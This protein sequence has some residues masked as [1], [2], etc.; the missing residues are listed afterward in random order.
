MNESQHGWP[1]YIDSGICVE[2]E[3]R[4]WDI[5]GN[6][7]VFDRTEKRG[8]RFIRACSPGTEAYA[9][10][11][12]ESATGLLRI[13]KLYKSDVPAKRF[14]RIA[15]LIS[16]RLYEW[17]PAFLGVPRQW[18][19][20]T[21][22]GQP[23]GIDR[24][25]SGVLLAAVPGSTWKAW[26]PQLETSEVTWDDNVRLTLA[27]QLIRSLAIL[28]SAGL[29]HGDISEGNVLI[30]V[31][32]TD[33]QL[34]LI[35]FDGFVFRPE[36]N[37]GLIRRWAIKL[38]RRLT[39]IPTLFSGAFPP[40]AV[41]D[42]KLTVAE[43]GTIGTPYYA[44][45]DLIQKCESE[46]HID[47]SPGTDL[48]ARDILLIELLCLGVHD[49]DGDAPLDW[50]DSQREAAVETIQASP[51]PMQHLVNG[52]QLDLSPRQ[53]PTSIE[54]AAQ[55]SI[56][57]PPVHRL[58][59]TDPLVLD[60]TLPPDEPTTTV[61]K[62]IERVLSHAAILLVV[63]LACNWLFTHRFRSNSISTSE[64]K[65]KT[66]SVSSEETD[67]N[68]LAV[69]RPELLSR[70]KS[71]S[72]DSPTVLETDGDS[73][74][75]I[76]SD[77][78]NHT[79]PQPPI[80]KADLGFEEIDDPT[81]VPG[82]RYLRT[83]KKR[84]LF[85]RLSKLEQNWQRQSYER[86]RYSGF[87]FNADGTLLG[88]LRS[89]GE[90]CVVDTTTNEIKEH[91]NFG[92]G[93]TYRYGRMVVAST[94]KVTAL[95]RDL[96]RG[97]VSP[98]ALI[99]LETA[100]VG[101]PDVIVESATLNPDYFAVS[102]DG[103]VVVFAD[104]KRRATIVNIPPSF[105]DEPAPEVAFTLGVRR[106]WNQKASERSISFSS[107]PTEFTDARVGSISLSD[108]GNLV[109]MGKFET[110][111]MT[112]DVAVIDTTTLKR[113]WEETRT[114]TDASVFLPKCALSPDGEFLF[115]YRVDE[116]RFQ[117]THLPSRNTV[118]SPKVRCFG[119]SVVPKQ[120]GPIPSIVGFAYDAESDGK[121]FIAWNPNSEV[122]VTQHALPRDIGSLITSADGSTLALL[123]DTDG[124]VS[125]YRKE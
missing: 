106:D 1:S 44:P 6:S 81:L 20:T 48:H 64:N 82:W 94:G 71:D 69:P 10:R 17:D 57:L 61:R 15:W 66:N 74:A 7:I 46:D 60:G 79:V 2:L 53:R 85:K 45:P 122:G 95:G 9:L 107:A 27:R 39:G 103:S 112:V 102:S 41:E 42:R 68:G 123:N 5:D 119:Y 50:N 19:A 124:T 34:Y 4:S 98:K 52:G 67:S 33:T 93:D 23:K 110:G 80:A 12:T 54:L 100:A 55:W 75:S 115:V 113:V 22:H 96:W 87:D 29:T 24:Q 40:L 117:C 78:R 37:C 31:T 14:R 3:G 16:Q 59:E 120:L 83:Y 77:V 18:L 90:G 63:F 114:M 38:L 35:D 116:E 58:N 91:F 47:L 73:I 51:L 109:A 49:F 65:S 125:L 101:A 76:D 13:V 62:Q 104:G 32:A 72:G 108:D 88:V 99:Y 36:D 56:P 84:F 86:D 28:E 26:K 43:G 25:F 30:H 70:Q 97:D 121:L 89:D 11:A 92:G 111:S 118:F 8:E 21:R 105:F